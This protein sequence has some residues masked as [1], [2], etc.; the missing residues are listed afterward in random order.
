MFDRY[1]LGISTF[2]VSF[3]LVLMSIHLLSARG[4][5]VANMNTSVAAH[6][7]QYQAVLTTQ[8]ANV[9]AGEPFILT[10]DILDADGETPVSEF[11][12]VH[13]K[14][15]HLILVSQDLTEFLHVHPDYQG[16][17][18]FVLEALEVPISANYIVFADF[19]PTGNHQQVV[20][21]TL[22]TQNAEDISAELAVTEPE[23]T[24]APLKFTL[25]V[26]QTLNANV[27][28]TIQFYV[29]DAETGEPVDTLDEYLGAAGHLVIVDESGEVYLHTHPAGHDTENMDGMT[30]SYGPDLEFETQFP[31]T[32]KYKMWLQVQY[33]GEIYTAPFVVDVTG[34]SETTPEATSHTHAGHG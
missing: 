29:T 21:L 25:A 9:N 20:R 31:A 11:D 7:E 30:M 27:G 26:P 8:P 1:S 34:T 4:E 23:Y 33:D 19:T 14:L 15:L 13:T 18:R 12:E 32:G 10:L 16:N 22:P 3:I 17:G 6:N 28:T 24:S 2:L 5:V